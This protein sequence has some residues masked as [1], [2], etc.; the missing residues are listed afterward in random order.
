MNPALCANPV[1][2]PNVSKKSTK[3]KVKTTTQNDP[4]I[5]S[6]H[7]SCILRKVGAM[8]GIFPIIP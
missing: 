4:V 3:K 5:K 1:K 7:V 8:L 2:V 6:P